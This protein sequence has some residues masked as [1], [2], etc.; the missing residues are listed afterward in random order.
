VRPVLG[1][2]AETCADRAPRCAKIAEVTHW[3][4]RAAIMSLRRSPARHVKG[5]VRCGR[6]KTT[7]KPPCGPCQPSNGEVSRV[8]TRRR[9]AP[10]GKL[11]GTAQLKDDLRL[12]RTVTDNVNRW[13]ELTG[14]CASSDEVDQRRVARGDLYGE[15]HGDSEKGEL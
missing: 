13:R 3:R 2:R 10:T 4:G 12:M 5:E 15:D 14:R 6:L 9:S 1:A 8:A 11:G 7:I